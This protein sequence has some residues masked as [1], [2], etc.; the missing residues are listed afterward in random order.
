MAIKTKNFWILLLCMLAGVTVGDF[1]GQVCE[2]VT[3]LRF[4]NIG[5]G[6]GLETPLSLDLGVL[7]ISFKC[8]IQITLAGV[9]GL[10]GGILL[11]KKI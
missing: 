9:I 8:Q 6:F 5:R 10:I 3:F 11:Y 1:I 7:F 2:G 4:L